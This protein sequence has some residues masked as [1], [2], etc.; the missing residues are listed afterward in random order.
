MYECSLYYSST[1]Y[2]SLPYCSEQHLSNQSLTE[3]HNKRNFQRGSWT[4]QRWRRLSRNAISSSS[5]MFTCPHGS[6]DNSL[7]K[8]FRIN[9]ILSL[10]KE[11]VS[12]PKES[13]TLVLRPE[14]WGADIL[15]G[16]GLCRQPCAC[17]V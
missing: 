11:I 10:K 7:T 5:C 15:S 8:S 9:D 13:E 2:Y 16:H 6:C 1:P 4:L 17:H 12:F 14:Y 3:L